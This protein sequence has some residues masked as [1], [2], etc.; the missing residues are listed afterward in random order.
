[1]KRGYIKLHR[2]FFEHALW[3]ERRNYSRAEAFLDMIQTASFK[4]SKRIIQGKLIHLDAGE[5]VASERYLS[6]RWGWSRTKVRKFIELL[7]GDGMLDQRKDQSETVLIL[8][9]YKD[10]AAKDG[11]EK[12]GEDTDERPD[13]DQPETDERPEKDQPE[14]EVE[15]GEEGKEG[16]KGKKGKEIKDNGVK[17]P[18]EAEE[19]ERLLK[20]R[21]GKLFR[22]TERRK[23]DKGEN[24]AWKGTSAA[25]RSTTE[26]EWAVL[27]SYYAL[28]DNVNGKEIYKRRS[29][30]VLLNNW[31]SELSKAIEY[32][33][34]S[35]ADAV[36]TCPA[37][38]IAR[39]FNETL[40]AKL[41]MISQPTDKRRAMVRTAWKYP[42]IGQD[43]ENIKRLFAEVKRSKFL[44]GYA[45]G[46]NFKAS[47][48]WI[49]SD[50]D[51]IVRIME[52]QFRDEKR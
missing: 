25:V 6:E 11:M 43:F 39:T 8:V 5:L 1:M 22:Y 14:T 9:K 20:L 44:M 18:S 31:N 33:R 23:W 45:P 42:V 49:F 2:R 48:D 35:P 38:D 28:P 37:G 29:L 7:K 26:E 52:G 41:G 47:Y 34:N 27:E 50:E 36:D 13:E 46:S 51:R 17:P 15:E 19:R 21:C 30:S 3:E 24:A 40:G 16:E 32:F 10:Y 4:A 12:T